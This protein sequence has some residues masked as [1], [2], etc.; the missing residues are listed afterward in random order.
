MEQENNDYS[1]SEY[2]NWSKYELIDTLSA[3]EKEITNLG[4]QNYVIEIEKEDLEDE[5]E[6]LKRF[7]EDRE[8]EVEGLKRFIED[9]ENE[10]EG[11]K[12]QK[13]LSN[14]MDMIDGL[15]I[16]GES[17]DILKL[18]RLKYKELYNKNLYEIKKNKEVKN[19]PK[20]TYTVLYLD[21][22]SL[23]PEEEQNKVFSSLNS[24]SVYFDT[25][26][27]R[28]VNVIYKK[29]EVKIGNHTIKSVTKNLL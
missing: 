26:L 18:A 22:E 8:N 4:N 23:I 21:K 27:S 3:R 5:I 17:C 24:I 9:R 19:K 1:N 28:L 11:L 16:L 6:G 15:E 2:M 25:S 29:R 20:H 10:V 12:K 13:K 14:L 7:I